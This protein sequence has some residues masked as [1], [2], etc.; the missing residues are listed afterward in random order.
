MQN[1]ES[2]GGGRLSVVRARRTGDDMSRR[3]GRHKSFGQPMSPANKNGGL[4]L[5]LRVR[6]AFPSGQAGWAIP[7]RGTPGRGSRTG[8]FF[9]N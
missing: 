9:L 8:K 7:L 3:G 6:L 2:E 5:S 1:A 4:D